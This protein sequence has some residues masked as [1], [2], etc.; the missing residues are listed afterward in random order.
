MRMR[1]LAFVVVAVLVNAAPSAAQGRERTPV[2]NTG[3]WAIGGAIGG[4][5]PRDP[6]LNG[7]VDIAASV[8]RY[9][10][11]RV[12]IRAQLGG[13]WNDIVNRG[14]TGTLSPVFLDGNI[15]YN[16]EGGAWHPFLTGGVGMYRYRSFENQTRSMTDTSAGLD[17]G[18]GIE[19]F[20]NRH[21][22]FDG[23]LLYHAVGKVQTP[24]T[25]FNQGEFWTFT[26][27]VKRYF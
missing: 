3:M 18:G 19:Y 2:P 14:F 6:S 7:K 9:F 17:G 5:A 26:V 22:T 20:V 24:L 27:G 1:L 11:P 13:E 15:V 12:S 25:T 21:V 16:W 23:E 10:S 8:E 4:G